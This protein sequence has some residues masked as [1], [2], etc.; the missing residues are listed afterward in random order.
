MV[1]FL[2]VVYIVYALL[3]AGLIAGLYKVLR[4]DQPL[5]TKTQSISIVVAFRD[6]AKTIQ[7]L[8][9]QLADQNYPAG[10]YEVILVDDHSTDESSRLVR[11][12]LVHLH[13]FRLIELDK[14]QGKKAAL[15]KGISLSQNEIIVTTDADTSRG[16]DWLMSINR[17]FPSQTQMLIGPVNIVGGA[18]LFSQLQSLEFTSL[19]A[20]TA[21]TAACNFPIMCNGAN[22]A[23]RKGAFRTVDGYAGNDHIASGDDE[24]LMRKVQKKF[25]GSIRFLADKHAIVTTE[26]KA[27]LQELVSQRV[28][29]A[30]KWKFNII[31]VQALAIFIVLVHAC[32]LPSAFLFVMQQIPLTLFAFTIASKCGLEIILLRRMSAYLNNRWRWHH[33]AAMQFIYPMYV[34]WVGFRSLRGTYEWKGRG[35]VHSMQRNP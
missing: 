13:N 25:P 23:F 11:D 16:S 9:K 35:L 6:E 22:L 28:R 10:Q 29:W 3:L 14:T 1:T 30:S 8:I 20:T 18:S 5:E 17:G 21:A 34:I 26:G 4:I 32:F 24:F 31:S 27:T 7:N 2:W 19:L 15:A 33:F 12:A